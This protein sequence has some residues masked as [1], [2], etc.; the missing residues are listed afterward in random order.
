[1]EFMGATT[2]TISPQL[3]SLGVIPLVLGSS[4]RPLL[5]FGTSKMNYNPSFCFLGH[6]YSMIPLILPAPTVLP[7]SLIAKRKPF[8]KATG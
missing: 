2:G 3:Q 8:S 7:P 1:M 5:T 4:I 6:I